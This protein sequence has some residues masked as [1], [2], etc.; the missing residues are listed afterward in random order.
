MTLN[1]HY[2]HSTL[3]ARLRCVCLIAIARAQYSNNYVIVTEYCNCDEEKAKRMASDGIKT[4]TA[5]NGS[6]LNLTEFND[7]DYFDEV[8]SFEGG[9]DTEEGIDH[10]LASEAAILGIEVA[11]LITSYDSLYDST[12]TV[13]SRHARTGSSASQISQTTNATSRSSSD[14]AKNNGVSA[15]FDEYDQF[16]QQLDLYPPPSQPAYQQ[17]PSLFSVSTKK[18]YS[19]IRDG[20]KS[21]F[22]LRRNK[23]S[24]AELK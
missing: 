6:A 3:T 22:R 21:R 12:G 9:E 24:T 2:D 4:I 16:I 7:T 15:S 19:S 5:S 20:I 14:D 18:S 1:H 17:A 23:P 8:L 10:A 13:Q 11:P